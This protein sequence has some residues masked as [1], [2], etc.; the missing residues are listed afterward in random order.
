[1]A[2]KIIL[3]YK[4]Y[5][6]QQSNFEIFIVTL[7]AANIAAQETAMQTLITA[8]A[9]IGLGVLQASTLV[10]DSDDLSALKASSPA[11]RRETKWLLT[12]KDNVDFHTETKEFP[13]VDTTNAA[14]FGTDGEAA[15][16]TA[17]EWVAFKSAVEAVY[18]TNTGH[19]ATLDSARLVGRNL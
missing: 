10:A 15:D 5:A 1:M 3:R 11:A 8:A 7:S 6:N 16:L 4:D 12:F 9:D 17:A 2:G 18:R 14:L 13:M 19:S